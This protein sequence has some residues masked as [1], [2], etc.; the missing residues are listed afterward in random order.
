MVVQCGKAMANKPNTSFNRTAEY[1]PSRYRKP[2]VA[3]AG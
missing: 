2:A 3:A 1:G